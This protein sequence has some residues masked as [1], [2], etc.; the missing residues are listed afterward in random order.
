MTVYKLF[1]SKRMKSFYLYQE[2]GELKRVTRE[3][4]Y[5]LLKNRLVTLTYL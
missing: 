2:D 3:S 1:W 4:V 5:F